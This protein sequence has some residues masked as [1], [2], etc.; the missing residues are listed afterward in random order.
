MKINNTS[1]KK[2]AIVIER[3]VAPLTDGVMLV[4]THV[5]PHVIHPDYRT[6]RDKHLKKCGMAIETGSWMGLQWS[7]DR[8]YTHMRCRICGE[9]IYQ[10]RINEQPVIIQGSK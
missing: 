8:H 3:G 2:P 5:M 7:S 1:K 10:D 4:T 9:E 6:W